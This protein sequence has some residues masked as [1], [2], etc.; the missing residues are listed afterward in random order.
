[1][2]PMK[3]SHANSR[4]HRQGF[5][6]ILQ[7][8]IFVGFSSLKSKRIRIKID[9]FAVREIQGCQSLEL[10]E[11]RDLSARVGALARVTVGQR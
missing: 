4:V 7:F 10:E 2:T 9:D 11:R 3:G 1:M 6:K 5:E 8:G